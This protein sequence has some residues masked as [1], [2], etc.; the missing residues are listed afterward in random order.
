MSLQQLVQASLMVTHMIG[1]ET[2][3]AFSHSGSE[4]SCK[5]LQP[6]GTLTDL[7]EKSMSSLLGYC[8]NVLRI[9]VDGAIWEGYRKRLILNTRV[10]QIYL[11]DID[12]S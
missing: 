2:H 6:P 8:Q 5:S 4:R 10:R 12:C 7:T 11:F 3:F 9:I 1:G